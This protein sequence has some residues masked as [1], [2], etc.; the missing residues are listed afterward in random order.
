[1]H[2]P[3]FIVP[4]FETQHKISPEMDLVSTQIFF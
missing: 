1:M 2:H 3:V 4:D